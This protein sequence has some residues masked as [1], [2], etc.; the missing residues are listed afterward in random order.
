MG[1]NDRQC[2]NTAGQIAIVLDEIVYSAPGVTTGPI[3]GGNSEISG[4]FT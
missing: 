2:F 3:S 1:R 4:S